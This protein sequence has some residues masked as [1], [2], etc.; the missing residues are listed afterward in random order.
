MGIFKID[1]KTTAA[2]F[3]GGCIAVVFLII[4]LTEL[5]IILIL[6]TAVEVTEKIFK[7][8]PG[9]INNA[10][11]KWL[12]SVERRT[13]KFSRWL[14][15]TFTTETEQVWKELSTPIELEDEDK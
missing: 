5:I 15:T 9:R 6:G 11:W 3:V 1:A 13:Y 14:H 8:K 12:T 7:S 2:H 10:C 4:A